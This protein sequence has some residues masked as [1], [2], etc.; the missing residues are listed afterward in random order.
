MRSMYQK[1]RNLTVPAITTAVT[2]GQAVKYG[3][4]FG[5]IEADTAVGDD[6]VLV[7]SGVHSDQ[8]KDTASAW[9]FGDILY[10]DDTAKKFTKTATNNLRV[11]YAA[12]NALQAD[13][14]GSVLLGVDTI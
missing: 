3:S 7:R 1:G 6:A 11:G 12:A 9:T 14:T 4:L 13:T 5:I 8:P 2:G 10:W